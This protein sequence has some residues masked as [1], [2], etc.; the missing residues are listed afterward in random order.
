MMILKTFA[1]FCVLL[2]LSSISAFGANVSPAEADTTKTERT[3]KKKSGQ[4]ASPEEAAAAMEAAKRLPLFAGVSVS[5]DFCGAMMAVLGAYGQYEAA[6]R[7]N[8][9][10]RYFPIAEVGVGVSNHTNET[11]NNYYKVHA[12]YFRLGMDYNLMKNLRSGN[13][14]FVGLRY[15]FSRFNYEVGGPDRFDP[16]Y[17]TTSPFHYSGLNGANHWGEA[18]FGLEAQV[19]G[20]L[21]LGWSFR[22]K[23]RFS[24][25]ESA[26]GSPW[27]VPGFGKNDSSCF[28]G[29]FNLI[30][31]ISRGKNK[32]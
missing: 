11:T 12:P 23:L 1:S 8:M 18:V 4:Y 30:F 10:G 19:W 29:T 26:V 3:A 20:I 5:G 14:I 31:D 2:L 24:N 22:Y 32:K 15:G 7:V 17:E 9:R 16:V 27:Y 21:H 25:K 6:A 13:R 28:G